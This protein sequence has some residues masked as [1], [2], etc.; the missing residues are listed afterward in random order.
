M[1]TQS[2]RTRYIKHMSNGVNGSNCLTNEC[3]VDR[4]RLVRESD[5]LF[6]EATLKLKNY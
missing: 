5:E 2:W 6:V 3:F 4:L 1:G